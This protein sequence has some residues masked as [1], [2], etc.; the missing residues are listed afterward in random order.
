[1]GLYGTVNY[2][3]PTCTEEK[4][5]LPDLVLSMLCFNVKAGYNCSPTKWYSVQN[6]KKFPSYLIL[7]AYHDK[8]GVKSFTTA[9]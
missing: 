1:M 6:T 4:L 3:N 8:Q 7:T 2:P 9:E 5:H